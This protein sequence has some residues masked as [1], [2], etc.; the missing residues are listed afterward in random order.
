MSE[1]SRASTR[2]SARKLGHL[3]VGDA[4]RKAFDDGGLAYA[5]LAD[6]NRIVL[7]TA[8]E[9]LDD[10]L[11]FSVAADQRIKLPVHGGL[12]QVA[13]ELGQQA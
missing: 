11:Q 12:S 3:A 1:R 9:D 8:A 6:Q 2:L 5:G 4:L 13:A 7:G 10:A